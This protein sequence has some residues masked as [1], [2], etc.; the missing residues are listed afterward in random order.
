[1]AS[2]G[3]TRLGDPRVA[4]FRNGAPRR[5]FVR[6]SFAYQV[7][8]SCKSVQASPWSIL[9]AVPT[10]LTPLFNI[11][12]LTTCAGPIF[13]LCLPTFYEYNVVGS[14]L[15]GGNRPLLSANRKSHLT[16]V[17][18]PARF[19]QACKRVEERRDAAS[20]GLPPLSGP[21]RNIHQE[22]H[23]LQGEFRDLRN[24]YLKVCCL[25]GP[26]CSDCFS[27]GCCLC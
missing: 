24:S 4:L 8:A 26:G 6:L 12:A 11:I 1:M 7:C 16:Y 22:L 17:A 3:V 19:C 18:T 15:T 25:L 10:F 5:L 23:S 21:L 9:Q 2:S 14:F 27:K 13:F 20:Q